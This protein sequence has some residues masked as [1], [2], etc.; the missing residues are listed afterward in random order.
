MKAPDQPHFVQRFKFDFEI[1]RKEDAFRLHNDLSR[2]FQQKIKRLLD[3]IMTELDDRA[4]VVRIPLLEIDLGEIY[5]GSLEKEVMMRFETEFRRELAFR[6]GELRHPKAQVPKEKGEK[7]ALMP[8]RIEIVAFFLLHGRLPNGAEHMAGKMEALLQE[9]LETHPDLVLQMLK[10]VARQGDN[11]LKRLAISFSEKLISRLYALMVSDNAISIASIEKKL[12]KDLGKRVQRPLGVITLEVRRAIFQYL[13]VDSPA[14]FDRRKLQTAVTAALA[15]ILG[16]EASEGLDEAAEESE[17]IA[18]RNERRAKRQ[19]ALEVLQRYMKGAVPTESPLAVVEAWEYL[20]AEDAPA[21]R[22]LFATRA[23]QV[24]HIAALARLLSPA[25]LRDFVQKVVPSSPL[26]LIQVAASVVSAF[27]TY[28]KGATAEKRIAAEVYAAMVHALAAGPSTT[29]TPTHIAEAIRAHLA[30]LQDPP[31]EMLEHWDDLELPGV[32]TA[33]KRRRQQVTQA[34]QEAQAQKEFEEK[35]AEL[36]ARKKKTPGRE[37]EEAL[38]P[39]SKGKAGSQG[40]TTPPEASDLEPG[41][42]EEWGEESLDDEAFFKRYRDQ[43]SKRMQELGILEVPGDDELLPRIDTPE[44]RV[45]MMLHFLHTGERPWW[46]DPVSTPQLEAYFKQ[47]IVQH[48]ETVREAVRAWMRAIPPA[49]HAGMVHRLLTTVN[50]STLVAFIEALAPEI[51]GFFATVA[52]V[53]ETL[54]EAPKESLSLPAHLSERDRFV[55]HHPVHYLLAYMGSGYNPQQ[56]VR[57]VF[58]HQAAA[59]GLSSRAMIEQ[60]TAIAEE[61]IAKGEKRFIAFKSMLPKTFEGLQVAPPSPQPAEEEV[62][63][64]LEALERAAA[65]RGIQRTPTE[66][67]PEEDSLS[68]EERFMLERLKGTPTPS[69]EA[70]PRVHAD[71]EPPTAEETPADAAEERPEDAGKEGPEDAIP[72]LKPR[73]EREANEEKPPPETSIASPEDGLPSE[74]RPQDLDKEEKTLVE[75]LHGKAGTRLAP[76]TEGE[77]EELEEL[78]EAAV[79]EAIRQYLEHG[80]LSVAATALFTPESFRTLLAGTL[81]FPTRPLASTVRAAMARSN[82]RIRVISLGDDLALQVI[83]LLQPYIADGL[84]PYVQ[85]LV[86]VFDTGSAPVSRVHVLD[87]AIRYAFQA[88]GGGFVPLAYLGSFADYVAALPGRRVKDVLLWAN[89]RVESRNSPLKESLLEMLDV[90][91]RI[92]T[93]QKGSPKKKAIPSSPSAPL[94]IKAPDGDIYI[95]NAGA[96]LIHVVFGQIFH[97]HHL[98]T[99]DKKEFLDKAAKTRAAHFIQYLTDKELDAPEEKMVFN[100]LLVGLPIDEPLEPLETPLSDD[101]MDTCEF[102]MNA[103]CERWTVMKSAGSDYVRKTFLMREGRLQRNGENWTVRVEQTG[104]DILKNKIPWGTNPIRLPW[105]TYTIDVD[106]P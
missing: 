100:K 62:W 27:S 41:Q 36:K 13:L 31:K 94:L 12:V 9:L 20:L 50:E 83:R 69:D 1:E 3:E 44:G 66:E 72:T 75:A 96:G 22:K 53:L 106:W 32:G 81:Q 74:E 46:A 7:I 88:R 38:E 37:D 99:E 55:W 16:M 48:P 60:V 58:K 54:F 79:L 29:P 47:A 42:E 26:Q 59:L 43:L 105:L 11:P 14:V 35:V 2:I 5:E 45:A 56:L 8:A 40:K 78:E 57:Y 17:S 64:R 18:T 102:V 84:L 91:E 15:G 10:T 77:P 23:V 28:H 93:A 71:P 61:A 101:E 87:H 104:I 49:Q 34:A 25:V 76:P 24:G 6:L 68:P 19:A 95:T 98:L 85:E 86:K 70:S 90:M 97:A 63:A 4:Y 30:Q 51:A 89:K 103:L 73:P 67:S 80:T 82:A 92:E 33:E 21:L 65:K 39:E 52:L